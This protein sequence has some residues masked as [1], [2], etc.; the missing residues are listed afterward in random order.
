MK[1]RHRQADNI[2]ADHESNF[3]ECGIDSSESGDGLVAG[4]VP[5]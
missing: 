3:E 2:K 1:F 5:E 4:E